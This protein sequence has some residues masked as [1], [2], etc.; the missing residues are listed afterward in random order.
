MPAFEHN[1]NLFFF[2]AYKN[3]IGFYPTS[4][5]INSFRSELS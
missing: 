1:G 2:A 3:H 5:E 4:S